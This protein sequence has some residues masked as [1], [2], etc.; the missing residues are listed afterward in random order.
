MILKKVKVFF[1]NI[2]KI[3]SKNLFFY[4]YLDYN[5]IV[6]TLS[7]IESDINLPDENGDTSLHHA[8]TFGET[9]TLDQFK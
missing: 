8:A 5:K 2:S 7:G 3:C 6:R 4:F 1:L 9:D